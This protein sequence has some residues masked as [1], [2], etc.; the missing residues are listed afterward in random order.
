MVDRNVVLLDL[1]LEGGLKGGRRLSTSAGD[2]QDQPGRT[3]RS[4][5]SDAI[6]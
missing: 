3:A 6:N 1:V 4:D 2:T 5:Q